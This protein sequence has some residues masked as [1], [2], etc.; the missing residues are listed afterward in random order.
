MSKE[1]WKDV[2]GYEGRYMVSDRGRVYSVKKDR[3]MTV[4]V[5]PRDSA[6]LAQI[7][8]VDDF[9]KGKHTNIARLVLMTFVGPAPT[10]RHQA[11]HKDGD[12]LNNRVG[13]LR[14]ATPAE[15]QQHRKSTGN[16]NYVGGKILK[17]EDVIAIHKELAR[18]ATHL[19]AS[20][21]F[22]VSTV[23]I[24]NISKGRT[25]AHL[26]PAKVKKEVAA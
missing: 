11:M 12:T 26:L 23:T 15:N 9:G 24:Y 22:G 2:P 10:P 4:K 17:E 18:G 21:M 7:R 1:Q 16:T 6:P 19:E 3:V 14:W 20:R 8:I 25:W 5:L 13:N